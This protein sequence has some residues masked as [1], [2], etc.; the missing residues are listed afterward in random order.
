[1]TAINS[2][3]QKSQ[4]KVENI[5]FH[6]LWLSGSHDLAIIVVDHLQP[7]KLNE[8]V[9]PICLGDKSYPKKTPV[10][11]AGYGRQ[12]EKSR[13][14][15]NNSKNTNN[16]ANSNKKLKL[17]QV[18]IVDE[19][20]CRKFGRK[21]SKESEGQAE[22]NTKTEHDILDFAKM[23]R[24]GNRYCINGRKNSICQGRPQRS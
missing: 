21:A 24:N 2:Y 3:L 6:P 9:L 14:D 20:K 15:K 18:E 22:Q 12:S 16:K 8:R 5:F 23:R 4:A 10:I 1:M 13:N 7:F 17:A 11:I 19:E